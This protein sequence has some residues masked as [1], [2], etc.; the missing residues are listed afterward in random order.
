M[1]LIIPPFTQFQGPLFPLRGLWNKRPAE[2]D[3]FVNAEI[4][5][6]TMGGAG[7]AIQFSL[8]GN[9]PVAL[10]QIVALYI[11]NRR[12]GVDCDFQFPDSGFLLTVPAHAQGLFPVLTNALM[13][14][15]IAQGAAG[16]DV[17]VVQILNSLPPPIPL[18]P[19]V[20][21][22][23][24]AATGIAIANGST[25]L[26]PAAI[27]GTLNT[28]SI[29]VDIISSTGG[30]MTVAINDGTGAVMWNNIFSVPS[31]GSANIP[32]DL[33]GMSLRFRQGL[34]LVITGASGLTGF[35]NANAYY[36]TP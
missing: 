12:C 23:N 26:V 2:G 11:D 24:N 5:W 4:D 18:V 20:Q 13:F 17:T 19:S 34:N 31:G 32:I 22:N 6:G 15:V 35:I 16:P 30:N 9:S 8:S 3:Y 25:V 36:Q 33:T 28:I 10:S 1:P 14:Y 21:Q 27:S 7:S 29:S